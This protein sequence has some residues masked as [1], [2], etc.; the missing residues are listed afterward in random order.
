MTGSSSAV[1]GMWEELPSV[2]A[3]MADRIDLNADVGEECGQDIPLMQCITSANVACGAHAGNRAVMRETVR[4]ARA[5][6]VSVGAHPG[7]EDRENFGRKAVQL[8]MEKITDLIEKQVTLLVEVALSEGICLRHVKAHGALYNVAVNDGDTAAAIAKGVASVD[9]N[10]IVLGLPGSQLVAAAEAA[11]LR[12]AREAF[13][14]R[15]YRA[16]G[17]LVPRSEPGAVIHEPTE[18]LERVVPMARRSDVDTICVHGD[19]PGAAQLASRIRA[20]LEA[21]HFHVRSL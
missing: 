6:G 7:Y 8:S 1:S 20:A 19:T 3:D 4:L 11:G 15:A 16:D 18:V 10:L 5:F 13:A 14:D 17:T 12:A 21:A 9:R 2:F